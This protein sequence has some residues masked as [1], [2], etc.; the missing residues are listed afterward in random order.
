VN[1]AICIPECPKPFLLVLSHESL[2]ATPIIFIAVLESRGHEPTL[3]PVRPGKEVRFGDRN[4]VR[5]YAIEAGNRMNRTPSP[6]Q[7]REAL[8]QH[9]A[10]GD[11][12]S[13]PFSSSF[14]ASSSSSSSALYCRPPRPQQ[15]V[16]TMDEDEPAP[17]PGLIAFSASASQF[18]QN[19]PP[20]RSD[21]HASTLHK[22]SSA[23]FP[24]S[25][26]ASSSSSFSA[27]SAKRLRSSVDERRLH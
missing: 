27:P 3:L 4:E 16:D 5:N 13:P 26:A 8:R 19:C 2:E 14:S 23:S 9:W 15:S 10:S 22:R 17:N 25:S 12:S 18:L 24:S 11:P 1:V 20:P 21:A 6:A 7:Q